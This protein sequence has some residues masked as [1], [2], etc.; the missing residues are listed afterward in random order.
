MAMYAAAI[1]RSDDDEAVHHVAEVHEAGHAGLAPAE[2]IAGLDEDVVIVRIVV[3]RAAAQAGQEGRRLP[4]E[5]RDERVDRRG[6]L[7]VARRRRGA[8]GTRRCI[9]ARSRGPSRNR[10]GSPDDRSRRGRASA[11]RC[12]GRG[13]RA[14]PAVAGARCRAARRG[15]RSPPRAC[16]TSHRRRPRRCCAP[17]RVGMTRG[18][19]SKV[20]ATCASTARCA[21]SIDAILERVRDLEHRDR[22]RARGDQEVL[23]ALAREGRRGRGD[24]P[25]LLV[26][27]QRRRRGRSGESGGARERQGSGVRVQVSGFGEKVASRGAPRL[28]PCRAGGAAVT[29][30]CSLPEPDTLTPETCSHAPLLSACLGRSPPP[31]PPRRP[32]DRHDSLQRALLAQDRSLPRRTFRRRHRLRRA[33]QRVLHG[34]DGRRRL[35]DDRW[36]HHLARRPPTAS[37]AA[38]S[39]RS[40]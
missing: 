2:G 35:Q 11:R 4:V 32:I 30:H 39:A 38:R 15:A 10:D 33:P 1:A 5:A 34:D 16:A 6:G 9:G 22:P 26:E 28:T 14:A 23:V 19:S 17:A 36:R 18:Q 40:R 27:P 37:S 8:A 13:P 29:Y 31:R 24:P 25:V 3:H 12:G 21:S 20:R 7:A